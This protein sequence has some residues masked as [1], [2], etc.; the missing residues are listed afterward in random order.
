MM[1]LCRFTYLE[2]AEPVSYHE[3]GLSKQGIGNHASYVGLC[4]A[5]VMKVS[6][7][8]EL[9]GVCVHNCWPHSL[10]GALAIQGVVAFLLLERS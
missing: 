4:V 7:S 9:P 3:L 10:G 5:T 6:S 1:Q 2:S 8:V